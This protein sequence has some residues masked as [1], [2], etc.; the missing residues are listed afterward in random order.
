MRC[1]A[2]IPGIG[3]L[4]LITQPAFGVLGDL[5]RDGVVNFEDFFL[6]ADQFGKKGP[7]EPEVP[8]TVKVVEEKIV[9]EE[10]V[11]EVEVVRVDTVIQ[12]EVRTEVRTVH[13]TV[14]WDR[15]H[16]VYDTLWVPGRPERAPIRSSWSDVVKEI[17][18]ATYWLGYTTKPE[19]NTRYDVVFVGTGFAVTGWSIATNYHVA[20]AI[21]DLFSSTP[22]SQKPVF[23]AVRANSAIYS[24][25]TYYLGDLSDNNDL[26]GFWHP[27]YDGTTT[28]PDIAVFNARDPR[29]GEYI[30]HYL[31]FAQLAQTE[32][33][34]A[35]NPGDEV[36]ILGFPGPLESNHS[37][38]SLSPVATFKR[39]AI[40]ALRSLTD[41]DRA[42]RDPFER[43]L[44]GRFVQ[45]D[46]DTSPGNSG[47][48]LF[49]RRAE[50]IAIHNSGI[51]G[52]EALDFGI[53]ADEIRRFLKAL[54]LPVEGGHVNAKPVAGSGPYSIPPYK[55][56]Y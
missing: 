56:P 3:L 1:N 14:Y 51:P 30:D 9:V 5:N 32:D 52:G 11:V 41:W 44:S 26:L 33:A 8:D 34:M 10:R 53:R 20:G 54:F 40:S 45:H 38:F 28:S 23:I 25:H 24:D 31:D 46:L 47:S 36:G 4:L 2:L 27:D 17:E 50:I 19:G 49:N 39:G 21:D 37:P 43:A 7:P 18:L 6:F 48:P 15:T 29:T 22:S 13:D 55:K 35:L 16:T 42:L 12:T